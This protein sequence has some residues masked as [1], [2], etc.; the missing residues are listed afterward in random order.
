MSK[1]LLKCSLLPFVAIVMLWIG[2]SLAQDSLNV[3]IVGI[4]DLNWSYVSQV[5]IQ[6]DYAYLATGS[7]GLKVLDISD[8]ES[9]FLVKS[10]RSGTLIRNLALNDDYLFLSCGAPA[11]SDSNDYICVVDISDPFDPVDTGRIE[12]FGRVEII[13]YY[14]NYVYLAEEYPDYLDSLVIINP[15]NPEGPSFTAAINIEGSI[16]DIVFFNNHAFIAARELYV[17]SLLNPSQPEFVATYNYQGTQKL[18]DLQFVDQEVYL[19]FNDDISFRWIDITDPENPRGRH[20]ELLIDSPGSA[21]VNGNVVYIYNSRED[22]IYIFN[23]LDIYNPRLLGTY[24][25]D[26]YYLDIVISGDFAYVACSNYGLSI[27]DIY[28]SSR[29]EEIRLLGVKGSPRDIA[30]SGNYAYVANGSGGVQVFD[31]SDPSFP[32]CT[33][34]FLY[35]YNHQI[36]QIDNISVIP[37]GNLL[38]VSDKCH[39]ISVLDITDHWDLQ[40]VGWDDLL[41]FCSG[42]EISGD[43]AYRIH[44]LEAG[45]LSDMYVIDISDSSNLVTVSDYNDLY[46]PKDIKISDTYAY[47]ASYREGLQVLD[48]SDPLN[49]FEAGRCEHGWGAEKVAIDGDFAYLVIDDTGFKIIDISEP[50]NPVEIGSYLTEFNENDIAAQGDYVYV[51]HYTSN[52]NE[53]GLVIYDVSD[54]TDPDEAGSYPLDRGV[55]SGTFPSLII[56]DSLL[57]VA[58]GI[59]LKILRFDPNML[60][61]ADYANIKPAGFSISSVYPNPFNSLSTIKFALPNLSEISISAFNSLGQQVAILATGRYSAGNQDVVFNASELSSGIYFIHASVPG[62]MDDV[63]KVVLVR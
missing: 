59:Y 47:V 32:A 11:G 33:G 56:Q 55:V 52:D 15:D 28:D 9:V 3:R 40:E 39:G 49:P 17:V 57:Y 54:P 44:D 29:I 51:T 30:V 6:G 42:I 25:E 19:V 34:E 10:F 43:Y 24:S 22:S 36:E 35:P 61:S 45:N 50:E 46:M 8:P 21:L 20:R 26:R 31:V 5:A 41:P 13:S 16:K 7:T 14:N 12:V 62:K 23:I 48:I 53:P 38:Y 18:M 58:D 63:K 37:V 60:S 1:I 4:T 27:L 2:N